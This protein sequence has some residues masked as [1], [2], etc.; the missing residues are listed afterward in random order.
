MV[1]RPSS[2]GEG[3]PDV[4]IGSGNQR[5]N[6]PDVAMNADQQEGVASQEPF[7]SSLSTT[8]PATVKAVAPVTT[9]GGN[10]A[11]INQVR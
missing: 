11:K 9:T 5:G 6:V 1:V 10:Y 4:A 3:I 2:P 8:K 7:Y